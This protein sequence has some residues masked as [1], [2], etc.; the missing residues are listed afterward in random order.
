MFLPSTSGFLPQLIVTLPPST[1]TSNLTQSFNFLS[2]SFTS[3][4]P[5]APS[6]SKTQSSLICT[7][8][9]FLNCWSICTF[10]LPLC[11]SSNF[12]QT[13]FKKEKKQ[14]SKKKKKRNKKTTI[15]CVSNCT[16]ENVQS[17]PSTLNMASQSHPNLEPASSFCSK[18]I[19]FSIPLYFTQSDL[20]CL[21]MG[22]VLN[23]NC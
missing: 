1:Q 4:F 22:H 9:S 13:D 16:V 17:F 20:S 19:T 11:Q 6:G 14:T 21:H 10:S 23:Y 7:P 18:H 15:E 3:L 12:N 8:V 2:N 5:Q